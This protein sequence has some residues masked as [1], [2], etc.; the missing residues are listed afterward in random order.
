MTTEIQVASFPVR[1]KSPRPSAHVVVVEKIFYRPRPHVGGAGVAVDH[2]YL[3]EVMGDDQPFG[4]DGK[5]TGGGWN[6]LPVGWVESPGLI[7]FANNE[8]KGSGK[9]L[10]VGV[11]ISD[12]HTQSFARVSPGETHRLDPDHPWAMYRVHSDEPVKFS[13]TAFPR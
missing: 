9:V 8:L 6:A 2:Q 4:R 10:R 12:H 13:V 7:I 3:R 1:D 5:T 11:V